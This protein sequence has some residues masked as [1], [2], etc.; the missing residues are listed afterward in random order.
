MRTSSLRL[1]RA[2]ALPLVFSAAVVQAQS[3]ITS[4]KEFLGHNIGDD[5]WLATYDQ[6][7]AFLHKIDDESNRMRVIEIGKS[8]EG[9]PQLA[10]IITAPENF[11]RLDRY[12]QIS[13]QMQA[14]EGITE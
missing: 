11:A 10:A 2:A 1:W 13:K 9:R 3:H 4:P 12:K 7:Q 5:Y 14:A 6:F 8:G